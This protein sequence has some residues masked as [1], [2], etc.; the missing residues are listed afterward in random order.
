MTFALAN[1]VFTV[2]RVFVRVD[3]MW[4]CETGMWFLLSKRHYA[5]CFLVLQDLL[6]TLL[7]EAFLCPSHEERIKGS[8]E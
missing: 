4:S 7:N 3:L 5:K 1:T 8:E 6:Y 2:S